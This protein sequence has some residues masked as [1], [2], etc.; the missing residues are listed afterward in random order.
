M[1]QNIELLL[2]KINILV[3]DDMEAMRALVKSCVSELGAKNVIVEHHGERA[4][5]RPNQNKIHLI[6]S[7]LDMPTLNGL[8]LLKRVRFSKEHAHIPFI[9][10]TAESEK[11]KVLK[12][13][14]HGASDY[15]TK[16]F[17]LKDLSY[18]VIKTLR[19]IEM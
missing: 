10:L 12:I 6:I 5:K 7:D 13:I 19:K 17:Q 14:K 15:M 3:V 1:V 4:W 18:R 8:E 2:S 16:P 11:G 9:M